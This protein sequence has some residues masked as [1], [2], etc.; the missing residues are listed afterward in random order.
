MPWA[1]AVSSTTN[2]QKMKAWS[3]PANGQR[4][5]RPCATTYTKNA[6]TRAARMVECGGPSASSVASRR[7]AS[8][9]AARSRRA[10]RPR[11]GAIAIG[12]RITVDRRG[13]QRPFHS[14]SRFCRKAEMPSAASSV[15]KSARTPVAPPRARRSSGRVERRRASLAWSPPGQAEPAGRHQ[16]SP[17]LGGCRKIIRIDHLRA[18]GRWPGLAPHRSDRR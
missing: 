11:S 16:L 10:T 6:R 5:R 3:T 17:A 14:A 4:S 8:A 1:I 15:P 7:R 9:S 13:D 18:R 2:P 12:L